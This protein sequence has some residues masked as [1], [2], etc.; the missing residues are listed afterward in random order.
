M[1]NNSNVID[2][3]IIPHLLRLHNDE[4][5]KSSYKFILFRDADAEGIKFYSKQL[6][7]GSSKLE[8]ICQMASS[9]E[10]KKNGISY[11]NIKELVFDY[12]LRKIPIFGNLLSKFL[13]NYLDKQLL[14]ELQIIY[15]KINGIDKSQYLLLEIASELNKNF[16][17]IEKE[18]NI[19]KS[20]E[21]SHDTGKS[22]FNVCESDISTLKPSDS[23]KKLETLDPPM[24]APT[25]LQKYEIP[26]INFDMGVSNYTKFTNNKIINPAVKLIAFYLPQFHPFP[27]NDV[28]WGKGF[29]EWTNVGKARP[30]YVGHYQPHCPIHLGYYDLRLDSI[31]VEQAAL[32]KN[33]G[34]YGFSYYFYW[35]GGKI[36]MEAPL[37]SML[38]NKDVDI[39]FCFTWANENW[40]RRW[41]GQENDILI[42]QDHSIEDSLNFIRHLIKYFRD[43][44][45]IK[46]NNKPL[47]IIYRADIIQEIDKIAI[48]WREELKRN[49][50]DGIYL[51]S[52]ETFGIRSPAP[53]NFDASMEFPPH[54]V[55]S[56]EIGESLNIINDQFNGKVYSYEQVVKNAVISKEPDYKLYRTAMLSWDNTARK[57]DNSHIFHEFSLLRYRQ[58]LSNIIV[59]S[60]SNQKFGDDEKFVFVN[61]W[62]EWA[63]G[64]HLEPDQKYGFA[65]LQATYDELK[66]FDMPNCNT[67]FNWT[68]YK[69]KS[70]YAVVLHL[71]YEE[72]WPQIRNNLLKSFDL[73]LFDFFISVTSASMAEMILSSIPSANVSI[74]ENRGR[75]ILPFLGALRLIKEGKYKCA[76]KIH[77][78][79]SAYRN[80]GNEI[81][82]NLYSSLFG[83]R[84]L[85][86]SI[87]QRFQQNARLGLVVPE[88]YLIKHT[89][90]NMTYDMQI[91]S[92]LS[93]KIGVIFDFDVFPAGSMFW[94]NPDCLDFLLDVNNESFELE[95]GLAD[96]TTAHAIERLFCVVAKTAGFSIETC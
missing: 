19:I 60:F 61:A 26:R 39:N 10:A 4:F 64:T 18:L 29:T 48:Q 24:E 13:P 7:C 92:S 37:I 76:C 34:I 28:W 27:E 72:L 49:G 86:S 25:S 35:F 50:F 83:S 66:K 23:T 15:Q 6:L 91:V 12:K 81:R 51:V 78:K 41:D 89:A 90:H 68:T 63:E 74:V 71:Y 79:M 69:K 17:N 46:I 22:T 40:S 16:T 58:W 94:F 59:G 20:D 14:I 32:A 1:A 77:S 55:I 87:T 62:N 21:Y 38:K 52:A 85:V 11:K 43:E 54:T 36:L 75:D 57:Q 88:K 84:E 73:D 42:S 70:D 93:D 95:S 45:Y 9:Y 47:L 96:G 33:Y 31:M 2:A 65:Y 30:N 44:R 56:S 82:N 8:I 80:D 67:R 53:F 5:I 3:K